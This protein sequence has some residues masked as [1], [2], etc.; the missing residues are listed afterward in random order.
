MEVPPS[1]CLPPQP[2]ARTATELVAEDEGKDVSDWDSATSEDASAG[3][4]LPGGAGG[5]FG[6][7]ESREGGGG[8]G[9]E[10]DD[11]GEDDVVPLVRR[12][13]AQ[14][15]SQ[16]GPAR[17]PKLHHRAPQRQVLLAAEWLQ[18]PAPLHQWRQW[19]HQ[20]GKHLRR[21]ASLL[22]AYSSLTRAPR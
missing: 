20:L 13:A 11:D 17:R 2:R 4:A 18:E 22:T 3:D 14:R 9:E 12:T 16:H 19:R 10:D 5:G 6:D 21:E 8:A 1:D 7:V 15:A